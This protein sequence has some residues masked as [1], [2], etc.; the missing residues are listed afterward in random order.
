MSKKFPYPCCRCG[1]CCFSETCPTGIEVYN[2]P[3]AYPCPGLDYNPETLIATCN[4]NVNHYVGVG[5]GCCML[6]RA[7]QGGVTY[8]FAALPP[9]T[10]RVAAL[11]FWNAKHWSLSIQMQKIWILSFVKRGFIQ[12][13]EIFYDEISALNRKN[14]IMQEFNPDYDE[15]NIFE[16]QI[17]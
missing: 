6:A 3:K 16:K 15:L 10:K 1:F 9:E 17:G 12:E 8:D 13:P 5:E 7:I 11:H 14:I 4:L 2:I